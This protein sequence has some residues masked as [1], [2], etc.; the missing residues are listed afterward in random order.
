MQIRVRALRGGRTLRIKPPDARPDVRFWPEAAARP[1][2]A[3]R[4]GNPKPLFA[5]CAAQCA[6][7]THAAKLP[8]RMPRVP[9]LG[10]SE[11]RGARGALRPR[12][13]SACGCLPGA[14]AISRASG[15]IDAP[16]QSAQRRWVYQTRSW[17]WF[18]FSLSGMTS[19]GG[20][21]L[22]DL[23]VLLSSRRGLDRDARREI[24]MA[25]TRSS[26]ACSSSSALKRR[27]PR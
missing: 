15:G 8:A 13:R 14:R 22:I 18:W 20:S 5:R 23:R 9:L 27:R 21:R 25:L 26:S 7:R 19:T 1:C 2:K 11:A 10:H 6:P 4:I 12:A 16:L 3:A 24:V 17:F